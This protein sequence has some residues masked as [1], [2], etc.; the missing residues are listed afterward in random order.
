MNDGKNLK[1]TYKEA[2]QLPANAPGLNKEAA[3]KVEYQN[4][5]HLPLN[6]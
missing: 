4:E 3:R 1:I 2:E 6:G 5:L